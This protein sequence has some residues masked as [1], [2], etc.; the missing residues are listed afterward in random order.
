MA[1]RQEV[2]KVDRAV[3]NVLMVFMIYVAIAIASYL[4]FKG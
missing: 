2:S 3:K 4:H 1:T